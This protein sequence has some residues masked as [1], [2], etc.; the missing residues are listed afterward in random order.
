VKHSYVPLFVR[1]HLC[2][3]YWSELCL[4]NVSFK[5]FFLWVFDIA[6]SAHGFTVK[7]LSSALIASVSPCASE[8]QVIKNM[9][10]VFFIKCLT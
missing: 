6:L 3:P 8:Y 2:V 9:K 5:K 1:F 10:Y 7:I 4:E